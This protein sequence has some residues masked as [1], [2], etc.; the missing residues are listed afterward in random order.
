V[1]IFSKYFVIFLI[2]GI[3]FT[4][5]LALANINNADNQGL[6]RIRTC[7]A[8]ST[9]ASP[10]G[11]DWNPLSGGDDIYFDFPDNPVCVTV[12]AT[13]YALVKGAISGANISCGRSPSFRYKP[14]PIKDAYDIAQDSRRMSGKPGCVAGVATAGLS[15]GI[16]LGEISVIYGIA[17]SVFTRAHVCGYNWMANNP[18]KQNR[19]TPDYKNVVEKDITAA[20]QAKDPNH[21]LNFSN[22]EYREWYYGGVEVE[23][24]SDDK[25]CK[26]VSE[27]GDGTNLVSGGTS[28]SSDFH[29]QR[30]YMHGFQAPNFG[31]EKYNV[32]NGQNDPLT[33]RPVLPGRLSILKSA[34]DCCI[35]RS[36]KYICIEYDP[37]DSGIDSHIDLGMERKFCKSGVGNCTIQG[38]TF[39]VKAIS[40]DQILCAETFSLCPYN[41]SL[42]G[43]STICDYYQDG[44]YDEENQKWNLVTS[45]QINEHTATQDCDKI[46]VIRNPDC[47]Y[48][49]LAGKCRNYCQYMNHCVMTNANPYN[50][51]SGITSPYFSS[52]CINFVGDSKNP[53]FYNRS[54]SS[55]TGGQRHFTAPIAQCVKE[56]L[57]NV[58][59][60]RAGHTQCK[61]ASEISG[62]DGT[63]PSG[64]YTFKQGNQVTRSNG[65]TKSFFSIVQDNMQSIVKMFLTLS[66][67]FYGAKIL[68]GVGQIA[69]KELVMYIIK[70]G[71]VLFFATGDAWQNYFFDGVYNASSALSELVFKVKTSTIDSKRDGCQFGNVSDASGNLISI[72]S[73]PAGKSYLALWDTLDCKISRYLAFGPH[74]SV[75]NLAFLIIAGIVTEPF[76][77]YFAMML[78]LF[79]F[80]L[81]AAALRALHIF[82]ASAFSIII[83]VYV[84]PLV[85]L[86]SLFERTQ[87]IFKGW[88]TQLISFC[89]Q[90][91]ILFA[92]IALFL[93]VM[94]SVMLGSA[95]FSGDQRII[96]CNKY[97]IS[98]N[99]AL[100]YDNGQASFCTKP[101]DHLFDPRSDS[102]ICI[103]EINSY[104]NFPGFELIGISIPVIKGI[105]DDNGKQKILTVMKGALI[106]YILAKFM[107]E[108][109]NIA[110]ALTGGASLPGTGISA[111][112]IFGKALAITKAIEKRGAAGIKKGVGKGFNKAKE[113]FAAGNKGKS[114][115]RAGGET[116]SDKKGSSD[117]EDKSDKELGGN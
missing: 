67:M 33:G 85:I 116:A 74:V 36:S 49:D 113:A 82:L 35:S 26:D 77:L 32:K 117:A 104:E 34:Y 98:T 56:T 16:A 4:D 44:L 112:Q 70:I 72:N 93:N 78:L 48:N 19:S 57:E 106:M 76:G 115:A 111:G 61:D 55:L 27:C 10:E 95:T 8:T 97:C 64:N 79:A 96:S 80:F 62:A 42:D 38:I 94:D 41:F 12:A 24:A 46:S 107:D 9:G 87:E 88:L 40:N 22:K 90:P 52:A 101:G 31:C 25:Q 54:A 43:G 110:A 20:I 75:A 108:I 100:S 14:S 73:Y 11:L 65:Q 5:Q 15:L 50:Y 114:A 6:N 51:V 81:I 59:Y 39:S 99:G 84:S 17:N 28:C 47:T 60:N 3:L 71:F 58:F 37:I 23:D 86:M 109:S 105:F 1:K 13:S 21:I 18:I 89:V 45:N 7:K 29:P 102:F 66:I 53:F 63:C 69:R 92:Y 83:M 2:S 91:M 30:Y 68:M 103:T